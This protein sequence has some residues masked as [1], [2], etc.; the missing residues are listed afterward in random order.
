M[1]GLFQLFFPEV[2]IYSPF[3]MYFQTVWQG[4]TAH[5][6]ERRLWL[7][8]ALSASVVVIIWL[9]GVVA[10]WITINPLN[11]TVWSCGFQFSA[12]SATI[13]VVLFIGGLLASVLIDF[14]SLLGAIH[15]F[16][17]ER[18]QP[19]WDLLHVTINPQPFVLGAIN[20]AIQAY[21][22]TVG[23]LVLGIRAGV[24]FCVVVHLFLI[25]T[26]AHMIEYGETSFLEDAPTLMVYVGVL[27]AIPVYLIEPMWRLRAVSAFSMELAIRFGAG[28]SAWGASL[29]C[30][31]VFWL[32]H[33]ANVGLAA[34][35][36]LLLP[37]FQ[38][39]FVG[40]V[41]WFIYRQLERTS[42]RWTND[43]AFTS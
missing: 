42:L 18:Q 24:A 8:F 34:G 17:H 16:A 31:F 26:F 3:R 6:I 19:R 11:C 38:P 4:K 5:Q 39:L 29:M 10:A 25:E 22:W 33:S 1:I 2:P 14:S 43:H 21:G 9:G 35:V 15:I 41:H 40:L 12:S 36:G 13:L 37:F 30:F 20:S 23:S 32:F 7:V 27:F 28:V